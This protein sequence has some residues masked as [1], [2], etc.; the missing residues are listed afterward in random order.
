M[1]YRASNRYLEGPYAPVTSERTETRLGV[2]GRIPPQLNGLY[3]RI[4]PNP[5]HV[6]NPAVYHWFIGDGMVHGIRLRDGS[7]LW[8]RNRWIGTD[9]V[10]R[11]LGRPVAPGLRHG[12]SDVVNT[13]VIG[14]AGRI[15]ALVEAGALPV[16]LDAQLATERHGY[17][18]APLLRAYSAH[19]H[20]DPDSGELHAV[21]YDGLERRQVRH[22]VVDRAGAVLRDLAVPVRHGPMIHDCALTKHYVVIFDLPVTFSMG[23]LLRGEGLPYRWNAAH[24]PRVGLL[25]RAGAPGELRWLEIEP[26]YVFHA[27]NACELDDG[28][29]IVDVITYPRQLARSRGGLDD[30]RTRLERW[31]LAPESC[32]VRRQT[33]SEERQEF[34]RFDERR[35]TH[36]YRYLYTVGFD[37]QMRAGQPLYRHDLR[38]GALARHAFGAAQVPSEVV[39]VPRGPESDEDDGWLLG[40]VTD[41]AT[42]RSALVILDAAL[43]QDEPQAV[44]EL[45]VRVPLG[46][47]GNWIADQS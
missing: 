27:G 19:P 36:P 12:V 28:S 15:W 25:P 3:A 42:D 16:Q 13:N 5:L 44:I 30:S 14:H 8:Y 9:S 18:D 26:C 38:T 17:F 43:P 46:F 4:G 45:P 20:R 35:A 41:L 32:A 11:R 6:D 10:N 37:P 31:Q 23:A 1:P 33:L 39:F 22:V 40:Y 29:V 7:A 47:H 34:P 21:C 24:I 2:R